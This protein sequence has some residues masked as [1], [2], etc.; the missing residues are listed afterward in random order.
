MKASIITILSLTLTFSLQIHQIK[1][2]PLAP[3][4]LVFG[5]SIVDPGNN[6]AIIT[7]VKSNF[8]PY[9]QN[10]PK[11]L[12]T[13]R[14]SNGRVPS[15][16]LA[17]RLKIKEYV[18]AYLGTN[19]SDYDLLTGVSFAS[20]GCGF[21]PLTA[22][23]VQ[24]LTM[25]DQLKLFKEYKKKITKIV[26]DKK[27]SEIIAKSVYLVVTGTD[28][29]ANTYFTTP[30]RRN[31][32]LESYIK[33]IVQQASKFLQ[34]LYKMGARRMN[35]ASVPP[36]GCVPS[37]RTN[38]GGLER[39]CVISYNQA[40]IVCNSELQVEMKRLNETLPGSSIV[41]FDMYTP[42][43]DIILHPSNY[44]FEVSNRG[45]CGTGIYEVTLT[46]NK[47]TAEPCKN[48]SNY[49]FWD[50]YHP[51]ERAYEILMTKVI[52]KSGLNA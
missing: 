12:A 50:T 8:A 26:G 10:F 3:A 30:F 47:Y 36:I 52:Q 17:S 49:V 2:K 48:V 27:A 43:L 20:G 13:G 28:D 19:L 42:L 40:A 34:D 11:H 4:V 44:G 32:D 14:F 7:T 37:Q 25:D 22:E 35:V 16:M 41:F 33:F 38:A 1:S 18:P 45:C 9:G 23:L 5:D 51:T 21:D 39:K 29:L 15:D 6:N 24:A 46:C 31:Y